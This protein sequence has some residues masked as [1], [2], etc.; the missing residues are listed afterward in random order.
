MGRKA[1][2]K[3]VPKE[4]KK[5]ILDMHAVGVKQKDICEYYGMPKSTVYSTVRRG[6]MNT[7]QSNNENHGRK[8]K[9]TKRSILPL[10]SYTKTNRF[11]PLHTIVAEYNRFAPVSVSLKT[12][13]RYLHKQGLKA[14][15]LYRNRSYLLRTFVAE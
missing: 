2:A 4:R 11:K 14:I 3:Q 12:V 8:P 10:L 1:G 13:K 15:L 7:T 9:L 6:R 5:M